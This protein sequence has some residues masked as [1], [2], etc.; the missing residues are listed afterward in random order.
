MVSAQKKCSCFFLG[1][2]EN[3]ER[4]W[5]VVVV[6]VVLVVVAAAV[7]IA[8]AVVTA[9]GDG[10]PSGNGG[11]SRHQRCTRA[12]CGDRRRDQKM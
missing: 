9:R 8:V 5:R 10:G 12:S 11:S 3:S 2:D 4:L 1:G 6:V 7:A